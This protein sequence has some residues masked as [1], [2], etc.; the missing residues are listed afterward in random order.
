MLGEIN[1]LSHKLETIFDAIR[2]ETMAMTPELM[3]TLLPAI[4]LLKLMVF[5]LIEPKKSDYDL[6]ST[7]E[8]LDTLT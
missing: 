1:R 8:V 7:M 6:L 2:K 5:E 3:D 4:D